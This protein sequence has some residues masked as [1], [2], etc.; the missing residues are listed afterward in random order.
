MPARFDSDNLNTVGPGSAWLDLSAPNGTITVGNIDYSGYASAATINVQGYTGAASIVGSQ[1]GSTITDNSG[2]NAINVSHAT[3]A[4][5]IYLQG[6]TTTGATTQTGVVDSGGAVTAT[7]S[8][9]DSIIGIHSGD[10]I[11]FSNG[12]AAGTAISGNGAIVQAASVSFSAFLANAETQIDTNGNSVYTA[13]VSGNTYVALNNGVAGHEVGEI[14][15]VTGVHTFTLTG[16]E[17]HC[18][19]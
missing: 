5:T 15:E 12:A 2:V 3:A 13:N 1:G 18:L 10:W 11:E 19:S 14:V 9:L 17:L 16:G 4:D 6:T 8:A 7:Q